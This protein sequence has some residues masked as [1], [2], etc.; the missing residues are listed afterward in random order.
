VATPAAAT[1][2]MKNIAT[3]SDTMPWRLLGFIGGMVV[4]LF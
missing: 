4:V 2:A 1:S 3:G